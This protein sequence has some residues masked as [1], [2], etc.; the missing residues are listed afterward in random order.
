VPVSNAVFG[1]DLADKTQ[2][3]LVTDHDSRVLARRT[4]RCRTWDLGSTALDRA[5]G[6]ATKAGYAGVTVACEPTGHP[7]AGG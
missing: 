7:V 2:T 4:F 3:V 5:A 6:K 1:I